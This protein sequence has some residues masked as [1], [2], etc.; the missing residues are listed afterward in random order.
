MCYIVPEP[1][2]LVATQTSEKSMAMFCSWLKI[3]GI[4]IL[5]ISEKNSQARPWPNKSWNAILTAEFA[6]WKARDHQPG[7]RARDKLRQEIVDFLGN[8]VGSDTGVEVAPAMDLSNVWASWLGV[9]FPNLEPVH[10]EQILWEMH[11]L[12]FRFE[13]HALDERAR[14]QTPYEKDPQAEALLDQCFPT[15]SMVVPTLNTANHGIASLSCWERAH[16]LF[17]MAHVMRR[18]RWIPANGWI[19]RVDKLT[20]SMDN[21]ELL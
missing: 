7:K 9:P 17:A 18:W 10:F 12:C 4:C 13:F 15:N 1:A 2:S 19:S 3:C 16:Y 14:L 21:I 11:E 5:S 8:C 20:W 6:S